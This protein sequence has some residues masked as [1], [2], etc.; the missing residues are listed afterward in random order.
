MGT[1]EPPGILAFT[2]K[3]DSFDAFATEGQFQ[4]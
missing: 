4:I 2:V 1:L 3:S